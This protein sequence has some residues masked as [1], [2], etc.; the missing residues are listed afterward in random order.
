MPHLIVSDIHGNLEA[1][2]AVLADAAGRY[3]HIFC[4]GDL[5]GYGADPNAVVEWARTSVTGIVRGNHDKA[6]AGL[7]STEAYNDAARTSAE[8]TR[9]VL[10]EQN[11]Q[12]LEHM[13]RGPVRV[14]NGRAG[15]DL[16]HGS[17]LDEDEYLVSPADVSSLRTYLETPLTF[18]GHTHLQGG[19]LVAKTG[20]RRL[21]A[22]RVLELEPDYFYLVNPGSVGQPRDGD[23]RA[24]YALFSPP[25]GTIE[26]RRT[27]YDLDRAAAKIRDAGLPLSLAARLYEGI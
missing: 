8:W 19:F 26:F 3:D 11:L 23:P 6:C 4:L 16:A 15:F 27:Q 1:L 13:P 2:H 14:V 5:V 12:Y 18:F 22:D 25:E 17:P 20:L 9:G 24:A 21:P 7:D 10:T